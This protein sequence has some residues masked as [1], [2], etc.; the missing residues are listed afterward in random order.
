MT[1]L[2]EFSFA[3]RIQPTAATKV[4]LPVARKIPNGW[5]GSSEVAKG[6]CHCHASR[7]PEAFFP[8]GVRGAASA[9]ALPRR[10][11]SAASTGFR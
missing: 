3:R 10:F 6:A 5:S 4:H 1:A 9:P 8:R 2:T 7:S 11:T